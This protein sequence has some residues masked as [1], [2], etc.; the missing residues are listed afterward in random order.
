MARNIGPRFVKDGAMHSILGCGLSREGILFP[1]DLGRFESWPVGRHKSNL[2]DYTLDL[3]EVR[4][5]V[6]LKTET[7][8]DRQVGLTL[9]SCRR[10][11]ARTL[12]RHGLP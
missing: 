4:L 8:F 9:E 10:S 1:S 5:Q 7:E 12:E 6:T 2:D 3:R 11:Y